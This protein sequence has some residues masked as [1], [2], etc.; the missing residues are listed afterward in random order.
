MST[1]LSLPL[2]SRLRWRDIRNRSQF[3]SVEDQA[4]GLV[5]RLMGGKEEEDRP[6][7]LFSRP[8]LSRS[9][10]AH[11]AHR[12]DSNTSVLEGSCRLSSCDQPSR[13]LFENMDVGSD[14]RLSV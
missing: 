11:P 7:Q 1:F 5:T 9:L 6:W 10:L 2:K 14:Q 4:R 8:D 3:S 13:K 12:S